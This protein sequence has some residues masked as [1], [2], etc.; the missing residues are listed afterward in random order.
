MDEPEALLC[1]FQYQIHVSS[2]LDRS[3]AVAGPISHLPFFHRT[4]SSCNEAV[5]WTSEKM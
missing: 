2:N 3:I 1:I 4:V 5:S